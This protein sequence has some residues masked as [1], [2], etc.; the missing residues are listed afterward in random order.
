MNL[1]ITM[2]T[3]HA[4]FPWEFKILKNIINTNYFFHVSMKLSKK[5]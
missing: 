2:E 4:E 1:N 3:K 5:E